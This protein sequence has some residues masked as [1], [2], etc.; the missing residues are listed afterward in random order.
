MWRGRRAWVPWALLLVLLATG[1][2]YADAG[3]YALYFSGSGYV[4]IAD[5][6]ALPSGTS[7]YTMEAWIKSTKTGGVYG[8]L[9]WGTYNT[10]N[11]YNALRQQTD[12]SLK[13]QWWYNDIVATTQTSIANGAWHHVAATSNSTTRAVWIN[14]TMIAFDKVGPFVFCVVLNPYS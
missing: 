7:D 14:G 4:S 1:T 10:A 11:A 5:N 8:I 3:D 6:T 12:Y 9:Q 2:D 13:H